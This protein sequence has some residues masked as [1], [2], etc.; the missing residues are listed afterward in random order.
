MKICVKSATHHSTTKTVNLKPQHGSDVWIY[1]S[2][3]DSKMEVSK[4]VSDLKWQLQHQHEEEGVGPGVGAG[5]WDGG[6]RYL[7]RD[8]WLWGLS[9]NGW[10]KKH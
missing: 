6:N 9:R 3:G 4:L 5:R 2:G 8:T 1:I 7:G 10:E